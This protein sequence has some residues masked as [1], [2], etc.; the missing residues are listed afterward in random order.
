MHELPANKQAIAIIGE[1]D[2]ID[3][4]YQ[5]L[6]SKKYFVINQFKF[7]DEIYRSAKEFN[8]LESGNHSI[9]LWQANPLLQEATQLIDNSNYGQNVD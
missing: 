1:A 2:H 5:F 6:I 4:A 8:L 9:Q 7:T 3:N